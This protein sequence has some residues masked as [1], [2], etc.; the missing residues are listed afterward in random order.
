MKVTIPKNATVITKEI[1]SIMNSS[2]NSIQQQYNKAIQ[3]KTAYT[4]RIQ[5]GANPLDTQVDF[6]T[7]LDSYAKDHKKEWGSFNYNIDVFL[8]NID[9][10]R[11]LKE[12]IENLYLDID[13]LVQEMDF[14]YDPQGGDDLIKAERALDEYEQ[15]GRGFTDLMEMAGRHNVE[16]EEMYTEFN[17]HLFSKDNR[18]F[19]DD[20]E[21]MKDFQVLN[22]KEFLQTYSYLDEKEYDNT[23]R[24]YNQ[25][26]EVPFIYTIREGKIISIKENMLR[27]IETLFKE[28][29]DAAKYMVLTGNAH[30]L[31]E[32]EKKELRKIV[33]REILIEQEGMSLMESIPEDIQKQWTGKIKSLQNIL[34]KM[35]EIDTPIK[36]KEQKLAEVLEPMGIEKRKKC[37]ADL[38]QAIFSAVKSSEYAK[39]ERSEKIKLL[40]EKAS[41]AQSE[42]IDDAL[43]NLTGYSLD[44]LVQKSDKEADWIT[45]TVIEAMETD[46]EPQWKKGHR[47]WRD[48]LKDDSSHGY[49]IVSTLIGDKGMLADI[50]ADNKEEREHAFFVMID[51]QS[52]KIAHVQSG[53][54]INSKFTG[55][56]EYTNQEGKFEGVFVY[57]N[58]C[59]PDVSEQGVEITEYKQEE[60]F[61]ELVGNKYAQRCLSDI[62]TY[63]DTS[64]FTLPYEEYISEAGGIEDIGECRVHAVGTSVPVL[65]NTEKAPIKTPTLEAFYFCI[66][67]RQE[68][69]RNYA[70]GELFSELPSYMTYAEMSRIEHTSDWES[71]MRISAQGGSWQELQ[72]TG[73]QIAEE[74]ENLT[75]DQVQV[76]LYEKATEHMLLT[77]APSQENTT[78]HSPSV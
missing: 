70:M 78:L 30:N 67:K 22:K 21:K 20:L 62:E 73:F 25:S 53:I 48:T 41:S 34:D 52:G 43:I 27:S 36:T 28:R 1:Y 64:A 39:Y 23:L 29:T 44:T 14:F 57:N 58:Y 35:D 55:I 19:I 15:K 6:I 65:E 17:E 49:K 47:L 54:Y 2:D 61:R 75:I 31:T 66:D 59:I 11:T 3:I 72:N 16:I 26:K 71:F 24:L 51:N 33:E 74:Y 13:G 76:K 40:K 60:I 56:V 68:E 63:V 5:E 42:A 37:D 45:D 10:A 69:S 32:E 7:V 38:Y 46:D 18:N 9:I 4:K 12:K 77:N 50:I 8:D